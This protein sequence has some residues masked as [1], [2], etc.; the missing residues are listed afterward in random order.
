MTPNNETHSVTK[1]KKEYFVASV[2]LYCYY[3][4]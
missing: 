4:Y 3:Y 1:Q 2:V